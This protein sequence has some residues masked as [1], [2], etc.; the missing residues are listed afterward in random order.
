MRKMRNKQIFWVFSVWA[1]SD[2]PRAASYSGVV[3]A[4]ITKCAVQGGS[5]GIVALGTRYSTI[6]ATWSCLWPFDLGGRASSCCTDPLTTHTLLYF[7]KTNLNISLIL[8][9]HKWEHLSYTLSTQTSL[10]YF[11]KT[12]LNI[13]LK[14]CQHKHISYTLSKQMGIS[15]LYYKT[16]LNNVQWHISY[17]L[18]T[19]TYLLYLSK[20]TQICKSHCGGSIRTLKV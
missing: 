17:T 19:Q 4:H 18:S 7:V 12:N 16:N 1:S 11:V 13:S 9:Q 5:S 8:C 15:L 10:L 20:T 2:R 3:N 6:S 14:L